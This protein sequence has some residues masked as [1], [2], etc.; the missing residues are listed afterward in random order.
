MRLGIVA[1]TLP[2]ALR[3]ETS[4]KGHYALGGFFHSRYRSKGELRIF[5]KCFGMPAGCRRF[6][7][8]SIIALVFRKLSFD[9]RKEP[10]AFRGDQQGFQLGQE[11]LRFS[12]P[13]LK[14][15]SI[16]AHFVRK[17]VDSKKQYAPLTGP[18]ADE[19]GLHLRENF[20]LLCGLVY[21]YVQFVSQPSG[22]ID[23]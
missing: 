1:R 22:P 18:H 5:L 20:N 3:H 12:C 16:G 21:R 6:C 17:I 2:V 7:D 4:L 9:L 10:L 13:I 19:I 11:L 8:L 15:R 14:F 23:T